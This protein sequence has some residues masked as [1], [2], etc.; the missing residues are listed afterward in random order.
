MRTGWRLVLLVL[1]AWSAAAAADE[2]GHLRV[3]FGTDKPPYIF[4]NEKRG[5]EYDIVVAAARK[6]GFDVQP[7]FAPLARLHNMLAE[8]TIDA[9]APTRAETGIN[10]CYS[11]PYIDYQNVAV[12]LTARH[13]EIASIADLANYS[14]SSFQRS[15]DMLGPDYRRMAEANPRYHEEANQ[16]TRNLLLYSKRVDVIVGDRRIIAYFNRIAAA[17][18]DVSQ[19]VTVYPL[20]PPIYFSVGFV[21]QGQC[22]AFDLGLAEL[23]KSGD[24]ALIEQRYRDD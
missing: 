13:L 4:E 24:Y 14:V 15:R 17:K 6:A 19:P 1:F 12:A 5:L 7:V 3:G 2:A 10:A 9:I 22:A 23:R 18:V 8:H 20:F 21:D 16:V 11:Q